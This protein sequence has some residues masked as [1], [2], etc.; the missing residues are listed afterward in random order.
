MNLVKGDGCLGPLEPHRGYKS[1]NC[2]RH[3]LGDVALLVGLIHLG[4]PKDHQA[5]LSLGEL[6]LLLL[7]TVYRFASLWGRLLG[8]TLLAEGAIDVAPNG[9][10]IVEEVLPSPPWNR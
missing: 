4:A 6:G 3:L 7:G 10:A 5:P 8:L 1:V 9:A 2:I